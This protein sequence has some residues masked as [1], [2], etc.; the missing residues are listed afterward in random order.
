MTETYRI[1]HGIYHIYHISGFSYNVM[2]LLQ[3]EIL[4]H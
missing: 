3:R 4:G 2:I 1:L